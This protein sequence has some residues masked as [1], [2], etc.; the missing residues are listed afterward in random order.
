[1]NHDHSHNLNS[2]VP[3]RISVNQTKDCLSI[4]YT[5]DVR[6]QL[7]AE[8]LRVLS[9]SA[10]V[11]GHGKGQEVLQFG[12]RLVIIDKISQSGNYA[13]Q[14]FFNDGHDSG[15]FTWDYLYDLGANYDSHWSIY[16]ETLNQAGQS[17]D[18]D[19]QVVKLV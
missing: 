3:R 1:M 8:Y 19:T 17:R 11:R 4:D 13:I 16:L 6:H 15:I 2:T 14:I 9:P 10:E 7:P 5:G 18:A 12:K